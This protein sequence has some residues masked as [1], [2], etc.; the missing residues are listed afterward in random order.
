MIETKGQNNVDGEN[1]IYSLHH[2]FDKLILNA[3]NRIL[4]LNSLK[5]AREHFCVD[6]LNDIGIINLLRKKYFQCGDIHEVFRLYQSSRLDSRSHRYESLFALLVTTITGCVISGLILEAYKDHKDKILK[7]VRHDLIETV[8]RNRNNDSL[9]KKF[10][11]IKA[12]DMISDFISI[13]NC[14]IA[15]LM[16]DESLVTFEDYC[17][18]TDYFCT[19]SKISIRED[20]IRKH[21]SFKDYYN[22]LVDSI[23]EEKVML[24]IESYA[25]GTVTEYLKRKDIRRVYEKN[26]K[27]AN[28]FRGLPASPGYAKGRSV[29]LDPKEGM[30]TLTTSDYIL[31]VDSS[32][33]DSANVKLLSDALGVITCNC[34]ITGHIPVICRG[35][36]KGCVVVEANKFSLLKDN[37]DVIL[38]GSEGIVATGVLVE[39]QTYP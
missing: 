3:A 29:V 17:S 35:M 27:T 25:K 23:N 21:N 13:K 9:I 8:F 24:A 28:I 31:C 26:L 38:S 22:E 33:F 2:S 39:K 37:D 10:C 32:Q 4:K 34:G 5:K 6:F 1:T 14:H 11:D 12:Q 15:R 18:L 30:G 7:F 19:H 20:L 36:G 16:L